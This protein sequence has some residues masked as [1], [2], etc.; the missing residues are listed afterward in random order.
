MDKSNAEKQARFRKKE[1]LKRRAEQVFREKMLG[2][3]LVKNPDEI[4]QAIDK[5]IALPVGW[6][7]EDYE[8]A[9]WNLYQIQLERFDNHH[10][11]SNDVHAGRYGEGTLG[12]ATAPDPQK[13]LS[14]AKTA[15]RNTQAL[16]A[17]IISAL[18]L[19]GCNDS[20]KAAALME[21]MRFVGRSL[22]NHREI[23]KSNATTMCLV[24]IGKQYARPDWFFDKLDEVLAENVNEELSRS[25]G[26]QRFS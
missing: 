18:N 10:Q 12:L 11:L 20:D 26:K 16:A 13:Y 5:A 24:S 7:D 3:P 6:T 8:H 21:V 25:I 2:L 1:S 19:S 17:H 15:L 23:P 14:E 22:L 4:R 9:S